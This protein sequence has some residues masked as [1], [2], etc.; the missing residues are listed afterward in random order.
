[1]VKPPL[2]FAVT[3]ILKPLGPVKEM[4]TDWRA[5]KPEPVMVMGWPTVQT[6]HET[7]SVGD[8][9]LGVF[10]AESASVM[11]TSRVRRTITLFIVATMPGAY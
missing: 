4:A 9:G 6:E 2:R 11:V 10:P 8:E 1:M 7:I 5:T 3:D